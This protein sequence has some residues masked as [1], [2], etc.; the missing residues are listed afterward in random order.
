MNA[1]EFRHVGLAEIGIVDGP[2]NEG[3]DRITKL[4]SSLCGTPVALV[5]IV[6]EDADRQFFTS[7][8]GL[9]EPWASR[10]QT[11]LS[12]SFCQHVKSS[13]A[14]LIVSDARD[15]ALVNDNL[16]ILDLG[17]IAYL[18][19]PI[20]G[21]DGQ[22]VGALCAIDD[23]PKTWT[24]D[25]VA[26][27]TALSGAVSDQIT[28]RASLYL[29]EQ[30]QRQASLF[31][32]IVQRA[33]HEVFIFDAKSLLFSDVNLGAVENLAYS[34][35]ELRHMSPVDIKPEYSE[36]RFRSTI[37][38][39]VSGETSELQLDTSHK[40]QDGTTYPVEIRLERFTDENRTLLIAFCKDMTQQRDLED[41]S[42]EIGRNF[43]AIFMTSPDAITLADP[44]T[45][46]RLVNPAYERLM[47]QSADQ[48]VGQ[49]FVQYIPTEDR[50]RVMHA[51]RART[52][53]EPLTMSLEETSIGGISRSIFWTNLSL[54]E[55]EEPEKI[56]SIGRDVTEL[57][58]AKKLAE[59]KVLE[60]EAANQMKAAF[61]ANMSHE[62]RTPL[63]AMMGLFQ[64]IEM[65]RAEA[66]IKTHASTGFAAG[67]SMARQL[68]NVLEVSRIEANAVTLNRKVT[69]LA[70]LLAKWH[71]TTIGAVTRQN[72]MIEVVASIGDGV[73]EDA[74]IDPERTTQIVMNLCDN[75]AKFTQEGLIYISIDSNVG[76]SPHSARLE[77]SVADTGIGISEQDL[78]Q[79]F[80]RFTQVDTSITRRHSGTGLGLSISRDLAH[81]MGGEL[82]A[83][84][85]SAD[86][87][88]ATRFVLSIPVVATEGTMDEE[89]DTAG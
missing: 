7:A 73:P 38:P 32:R 66:T 44:D 42:R 50:S 36:E 24:E 61:L 69:P 83:E 4:A 3:F 46:I 49:R 5:S 67:Q 72:K 45:T 43:E 62:V 33:Q 11:P 2:P 21:I 31:G 71:E 51:I 56:I 79:I 74:H 80:Q 27:L 13:G 54:F 47:R 25:E 88:Y 10:R 28:L 41:R 85:P 58:Q 55:D 20:Y 18:G 23:K 6:E 82:L 52:P 84:S 60:A 75:A 89:K 76:P 22:A 64:I 77:I 29:S 37:A 87:D 86:T 26:H 9:P 8:L 30:R 78:G 57:N 65:S 1:E 34:L 40:R 53:K 48:L 59:V 19:V 81:M 63:N 68:D 14:P 16:A 15:H 17:V 12:H 35:S 70:P 39:L